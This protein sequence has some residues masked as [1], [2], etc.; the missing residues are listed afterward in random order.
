MRNVVILSGKDYA[1][2]SYGNGLSYRL[3]NHATK[4]S[5]FLQGDDATQFRTDLEDTEAA[6]PEW[7]PDQVCAWLWGQFEY[8]GA[9]T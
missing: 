8:G 3:D 9:A 5:A 1:V 2:T 6:W 7:S 4:Q